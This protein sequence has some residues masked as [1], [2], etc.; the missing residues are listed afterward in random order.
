MPPQG[1][2]PVVR[3]SNANPAFVELLNEA[4][5]RKRQELDGSR[6]SCRK[7]SARTR[8]AHMETIYESHGSRGP[9][10]IEEGWRV[11]HTGVQLRG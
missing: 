4:L 5:L 11:E 3:L 2:L 9:T 1:P 6:C 7:V 10:H 8:T